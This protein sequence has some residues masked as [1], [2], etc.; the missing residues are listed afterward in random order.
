MIKEYKVFISSVLEKG[1]SK[2]DLENLFKLLYK[3][4]T[5]F[6][7]DNEK[8]KVILI[9]HTPYFYP[10]SLSKNFGELKFMYELMKTKVLNCINHF[11][12]QILSSY[13]TKACLEMK[14]F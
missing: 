11:Q 12:Y 2:V 6:V 8:Q 4:L 9:E 3:I 13:I 7:K 1:E 14:A 5:A 10:L